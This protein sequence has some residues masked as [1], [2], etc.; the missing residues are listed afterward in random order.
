M[1]SENKVQQF[2]MG[3]SIWKKSQYWRALFLF[4][5]FAFM[6]GCHVLS[7]DE[8]ITPEITIEPSTILAGQEIQLTISSPEEFIM[9]FC[10]GITYVIEYK[11][12]DGWEVYDGQYGPCNAMMRPEIHISK[13]HTIRLTIDEI[14]VYRFRSSFKFSRE[15]TF[16]TLN[17]DEFF[18]TKAGFGLL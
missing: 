17:S 4:I 9:P 16:K 3:S 11:G 13:K 2:I 10:G 8:A 12:S 15:D 7:S 18:V 5:A 14:G 1:N 6:S